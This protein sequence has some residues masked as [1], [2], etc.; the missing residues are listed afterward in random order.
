MS[1][2]DGGDG[3][4]TAA[5]TKATAPEEPTEPTQPSG[6]AWSPLRVRIFR[7][8]WL[9]QFASNVGS[10]MQTVGAQWLLVSHGAGQVALVQ[11]AAGLPVLFL[12]LPAGVLAD[13]V[14]R[15]R[16]LLIMQG[17]MALVATVL[18]GLSFAGLLG[19][20]SLL[21]LT[22]LLGCGGA[23]NGPAWQ[24]VQPSLVPRDQLRQAS[25][26]GAVNQN[27]ARAIG[28]ALGG[29]L[30]AFLGVSWTFAVNAVSFLGI[31]IVLALWRPS[32]ESRTPRPG[33]EREHM[34]AALRAGGRYVRRAPRVRRIL[35]RSALFVPSAAALWAL[36]PVTAQKSLGLGAAGY[37]LLLGAV[38]LGAVGGATALPLVSR[39]IGGNG[40][41]AL[42]GTVFAGALLD[43]AWVPSVPAAWIALM[44]AG[45]A[46]II[47][48]STLNA[49]LQLALPTWVRARAVA[50]YLLVFQGGMALGS[51]VW[52]QVAQHTSVT[53]AMALAGALLLVGVV[54]LR[55]LRLLDGRVDPTLSEA[56]PEP[57]LLV[58][59]APQ[60]GPVLVTAVYRVRPERVPDFAQAM[61][62]VENSRRRT[63]AV[64]WG[65]YRDAA[66]EDRFVEAFTVSSWSE[67]C[68]Q[69]HGRYTG[70]DHTFETRARELLEED[71][72]VTHAVM[73]EP[74]T[75]G[76]T[77]M[78]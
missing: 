22:F 75:A 20:W 56:W 33:Q 39:R 47:G 77:R 27:L 63:G 67:H 40:A 4:N 50:F 30:V 6:S 71:P 44:L 58:E 68:A 26:L 8:L 60:D 19:S 14:D 23:L 37:G 5:P 29:A 65:L 70:M 31:L 43:L 54:S 61:R 66:S 69:H 74:D 32:G 25:A 16:L 48:L 52:G 10:W 59:P 35:L 9:A 3:A 12:A 17:A 41:L 13:L 28:P 2:T 51:L 34:L 53:L 11:V 62:R 76:V 57:R 45:A 78:R 49:G 42:A 24:A 55:W 15:R 38:G 21:G 18:A 7:E 46:W 64:T 1:D 73:V 36:L 72:V